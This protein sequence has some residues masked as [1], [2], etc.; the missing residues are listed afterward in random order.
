MAETRGIDIV[1]KGSKK[2]TKLMN[3]EAT[4]IVHFKLI[5]RRMHFMVPVC[6]AMFGFHLL[7]FH[8]VSL[9]CVRHFHSLPRHD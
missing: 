8:S 3:K 6:D 5:N 4:L 9:V 7:L 1:E 2:Q